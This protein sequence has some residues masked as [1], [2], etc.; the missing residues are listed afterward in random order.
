MTKA[1]IERL[2]EVVE[3]EFGMTEF[4]RHHA[5][6]LLT[7]ALVAEGEREVIARIAGGDAWDVYTWTDGSSGVCMC[8]QCKRERSGS[9]AKADA[10]LAHLASLAM[11][12]GE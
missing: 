12:E 3:S 10:I 8:G 1:S 2:R 11:G 9:L 4:E 7:R 6:R 5:G